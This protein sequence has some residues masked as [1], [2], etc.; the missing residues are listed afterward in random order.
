MCHLFFVENQFGT[1]ICFEFGCSSGGTL[2]EKE[3]ER[4]WR[5]KEKATTAIATAIILPT[6]FKLL[7]VF[8]QWIIKTILESEL[9]H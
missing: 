6:N 1:T 7:T 9:N 3:R 2:K 4:K 5:E 8:F